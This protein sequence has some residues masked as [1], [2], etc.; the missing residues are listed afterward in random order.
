M[1]MLRAIGYRFVLLMVFWAICL[2]RGDIAAA[3]DPDRLV[4]P[5]LLRHAGLNT[6]WETELAIK[7]DEALTRL[8]LLRNRVYAV[9]SGNYVVS[10]NKDTGE[11]VFSKSVAPEGFP[12][13]ELVLYDDTILCVGGSKLEE[14]DIETGRQIRQVDVGFGITAPAARNSNFFY[15]AGTDNRLHVYRADDRVQIFEAAAP[16]DSAIT[17]IVAD[18]N[19]VIFATDTGYLISIA[20][21]VPRRLWQF[22]AGDGI[23]GSVVRDWM[24]LFFASADTNVYRLDMV[25]LP[26]KTR[27]IW[28]YQAAGMLGRAPRVT[29][30]VVYQR[31]RGKGLTA[32]D[33]ETG[34]RIWRVRGGVDLLAEAR[35]RAYIITESEKLI[36]MDN[37]K[38]NKLYAVN[39]AGVEVFASNTGDDKMYIA[40]KSGRLMCIQ[41]T[42]VK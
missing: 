27:L 39:F 7:A 40:D 14:L 23:A 36:V 28:K 41:P 2:T 4:S 5:E 25:G 16:D 15:V 17:S 42:E 38:T 19:F 33:R 26:E 37:A 8:V 24:T 30:E 1:K 12:I 13:A 6:V 32:V 20:P 21:D 18:D 11:N 29:Q 22:K 31:V 34:S 9:S 35:G 3:N 10:M